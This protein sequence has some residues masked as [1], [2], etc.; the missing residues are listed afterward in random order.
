M[1]EDFQQRKKEIELLRRRK[2]QKQIREE[3]EDMM[4]KQK[5]RDSLISVPEVGYWRKKEEVEDGLEKLKRVADKVKAIKIK[6]NYRKIILQQPAAKE[7]DCFSTS[8]NGKQVQVQWEEL[9]DL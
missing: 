1:R 8:N 9:A 2:V 4:K 3:E 6:L 7:L 5:E